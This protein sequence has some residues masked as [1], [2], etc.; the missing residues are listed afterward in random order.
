MRGSVAALVAASSLAL[1][2][3]SPRLARAQEGS[4]VAGEALFNEGRA[5]AE[6][7]QFA[8]ACDRF[9]RSQELAPAVGKLLNLGE[10]NQRQGKVASA[11]GAYA[12]ARSLGLARNDPRAAVAGRAAAALEP[13]LPHLDIAVDRSIV[14]LTVTRNGV[15][16]ES[17]ALDLPIP[18]DPGSH[19][20][21]VTAPGRKP[22]SASFVVGEAE[23]HALKV[24][25]L[26][27]LPAAE[28]TLAPD[29]ASESHA[30]LRVALGL[31][32]GGGA[33]LGAGLIFG[34]LALARWGSVTDTC[35]DARCP[36]EAAR[37]RRADDVS[38]ARTFATISTIAVS[39]GALALVS[40]IVLHVTAPGKRASIVPTS[41]GRGGGLLVIL[42]L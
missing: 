5:L 38:A 40:G 7:G 20:I 21:V 10:C 36:D 14:G 26:E 3:L 33:A 37:G 39:A 29:A 2:L 32:I 34:G 25:A 28:P 13:R 30:Q 15:K 24:P 27:P 11:W 19:V 12:Q 1:G 31:E 6:R 22:W 23:S 42:Q 41:D 17:A 8:E 18:V 4:A 9:T 35:P 16:I